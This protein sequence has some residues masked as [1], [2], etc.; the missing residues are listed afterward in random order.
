MTKN[1]VTARNTI[2]N[3]QIYIVCKDIHETL[4]TAG[5]LH[6]IELKER[7]YSQIRLRSSIPTVKQGY[8]WISLCKW[9]GA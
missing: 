7:S 1:I 4:Q 6:N 2:T 8:R 9:I 5:K 3:E